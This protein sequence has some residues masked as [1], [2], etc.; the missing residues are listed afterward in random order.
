MNTL[1]ILIVADPQFVPIYSHAGDAGA[2]LKSAESV[3]LLAGQRETVKTGVSIAIPSGYVGLVH[4]RSGLAA[5]HGI[6]VLN[7]PGTV[8]AGYRG[9]IAVTLFNS[10]GVDYRIE[11]G[12]RIAQIVFQSVERA[13]FVAVETLPETE[14]G[15]GGFGSTGKS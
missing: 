2:D 12:D 15:S 6:T 5:K 8:D 1:P 11:V 13:K 7:S 9:E 3:I 4:A 14:R 10:S